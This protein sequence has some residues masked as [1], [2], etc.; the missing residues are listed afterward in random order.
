MK[1]TLIFI[2]MIVLLFFPLAFA[3]DTKSA[4]L[5]RGVVNVVTAPVEIPKQV[6]VYW[7]KGAQKTPHII[8]WIL[9]GGVWGTVQAVKRTGSGVWD[10]VSFPFAKPEKFGPL[11]KP[12]FVFDEWP[13][14]PKRGR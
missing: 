6:R 8:V 1:R 4:K 5:Y 14:N 11:M 9:S 2:T 10:V 7:I 3:E 12:D 13:R